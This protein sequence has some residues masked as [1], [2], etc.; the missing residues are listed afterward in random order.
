[1]PGKVRAL[2]AWVGPPPPLTK[3]YELGSEKEEEALTAWE[4][5]A[6]PQ[7]TELLCRAGNTVLCAQAGGAKS[8][9]TGQFLEGS[10]GQHGWW[11]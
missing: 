10:T 5:H 8:V 3:V 11:A 1:M 4:N 6:R 9:G 2:I 7:S